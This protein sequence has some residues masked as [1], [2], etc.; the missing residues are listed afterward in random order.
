MHDS[1]IRE[2]YHFWYLEIS[3]YSLKIKKPNVESKAETLYEEKVI[4]NK[5]KTIILVFR[6]KNG[7][8]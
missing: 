5:E 2:R 6:N 8:E 7:N 1:F 3:Q 4:L